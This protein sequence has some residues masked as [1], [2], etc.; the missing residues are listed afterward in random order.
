MKDAKGARMER[1]SRWRRAAAFLQKN[2]VV[3]LLLALW[4]ALAFGAGAALGDWEQIPGTKAFLFH[5]L[6][7]G[8]E[9]RLRESIGDYLALEEQGASPESRDAALTAMRERSRDLMEALWSG[10]GYGKLHAVLREDGAG[11]QMIG[12][13]W[14]YSVQLMDL[15]TLTHHLAFYLQRHGQDEDGAAYAKTLLSELWRNAFLENAE[16]SIE[17][18]LRSGIHTVPQRSPPPGPDVADKRPEPGAP[19]GGAARGDGAGIPPRLP[20]A[21]GDL[22]GGLGG[23]ERVNPG[24]DLR[25]AGGLPG[26]TP[27]ARKNHRFDLTGTAEK[28]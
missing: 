24:G 28:F 15:S 17:G 21:P 19:P 9:A 3:I 14:P 7:D 5:Q 10:G 26:G 22:G 2:V 13:A 16:T 8:A 1:G 12:N 27:A 20:A 4:S 18:Y 11:D 23:G 25:A 6:S